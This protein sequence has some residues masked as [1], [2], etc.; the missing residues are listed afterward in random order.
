MQRPIVSHLRGPRAGAAAALVVGILGAFLA[1]APAAF[2]HHPTI[3]ADTSCATSSGYVVDFTS[4]SWQ[5]SGGLTGGGANP[6]IDIYYRFGSNGAA[7]TP[8]T[9]LPWQAGYLYS[10]SNNYQFSDSF[11]VADLSQGNEVQLRAH[12]TANWGNGAGGGQDTDTDWQAFPTNCQTP[13]SP[14]V[15]SSVACVSGDGSVTITLQN[16]GGPNAKAVHFEV[17]NPK[18]GTVTTRDV[19]PG[20]TDTVTL[21]GFADG[22]VAIQVTA[23]GVH[24]DQALTVNCDMPGTPDVSA[25]VACANGDGDVTVVL[26]NTAG[27]LPI[28]FVVTDPRTNVATTKVVPVGGNASVTLTGLPD[29]VITIP[30]TADGVSLNQ[31]LTVKCDQPGVPSVAASV[32][33][34][35]ANGDVTI[36]VANTGGNLPVTFVVTDPRTNVATTKVVA[37][38]ASDSVTL[39]GFADGVVVIPVTADGVAVNQTLTIHCDVPGVPSVSSGA[40]CAN[41]QGAITVTLANTGG[42]QPITFVVTDPRTNVATTKVV[43][44]GTNASVT[45]TGFPDG[46]VTIPVTAD[47]VAMNQTLTVKCHIPGVPGAS[48]TAACTNFDGD[49]AIAL[50][51]TGGTDAVHFIVTD[52]RGGAPIVK[53]VAVGA[54]ATVTLSGFA[55]GVVV[56]GVSANGKAMNQTVT[57]A[58]D[59][60]GDP[61]VFSDVECV[62]LG[63]KVVVTLS[64]ASQPGQAESIDFV[65]T[66]PR[67]GK[68]TSLTVAPGATFQVTL[69]HL[70]DG[71]YAIPVSADGKALAPIT[72]TVE[73]QNAQVSGIA[74]SC[75]EGGETVNITND[76]GSPVDVTVSQDGVVV[77]TVTVPAKSSNA[78]LVPMANGQT[79]VITVTDGVTVILEKT[80]T[81]TCQEATTTTTTAGEVT[82]TTAPTESTTSTIGEPPVRVKG[83]EVD[84]GTL[85]TTGSSST[86]GLVLIA[87]ALLLGGVSLVRMT[88]TTRES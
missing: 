22:G 77:K 12:A 64:N 15:S 62:A 38:G 7:N 4:V 28:T 86:T 68:T 76:G 9:L 20:A 10:P 66:D 56:I 54:S 53:D 71:D 1:L 44:P 40:T 48:A 34:A 75:D 36:T 24:H 37:V 41:V 23:D 59:R 58:C 55:D 80:V 67:D 85:P 61:A 29:G 33:C 88:R 73:C 83:V 87:A 51:N 2:A 27:N 81:H 6:H 18:D 45:L 21:T 19:A 35:N 50:T 74:T 25:S 63:G 30:V 5:Q 60:P 31:T 65:V 82:T 57:V 17:T 47:G 11:P 39:T 43:A 16:T 52:P 8:W 26:A 79:S 14:V 84:R 32:A 3:S 69:D 42:N 49:I 46:P 72:I 13:G 70:A 78:V